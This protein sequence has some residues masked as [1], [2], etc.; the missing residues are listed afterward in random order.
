[1]S[2]WIHSC[3][4]LRWSGGLKGSWLETEERWIYR[5][6]TDTGSFGQP[7]RALRPEPQL[8]FIWLQTALGLRPRRA[9]SSAGA[10]GHWRRNRTLEKSKMKNLRCHFILRQRIATG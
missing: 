1:M 3:W 4:Q 2:R 5:Y 10:T 9:L 8:P 6:E 7:G